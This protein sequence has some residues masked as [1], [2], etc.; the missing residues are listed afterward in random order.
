MGERERG[1]DTIVF[2]SRA[3]AFCSRRAPRQKMWEGEGGCAAGE[4]GEGEGRRGD[5]HFLEYPSNLHDIEI[6]SIHSWHT[7]VGGKIFK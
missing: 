5:I 3:F 1:G 6:F 2:L 4:R 7:L